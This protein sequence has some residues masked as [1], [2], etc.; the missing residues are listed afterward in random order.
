[1]MK[2]EFGCPKEF[3]GEVKGFPE[4]SRKRRLAEPCGSW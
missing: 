4:A 3:V 2:T 1:M